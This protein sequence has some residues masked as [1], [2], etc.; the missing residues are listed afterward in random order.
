MRAT[1][2]PMIPSRPTGAALW[3][4][5]LD[6][7]SPVSLSRQLAAALRQAIAEGSLAAGARLPS[8][9]AL[10]AE[11]GLA[12]STVVGVF[13]QL[14]A[15]GYIIARPGSAHRVPERREYHKASSAANEGGGPPIGGE[16]VRA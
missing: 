14:T 6:R 10:A 1:L 9:R 15:E 16:Q 5:R 7:G 8:S 11:L 12:R 3:T 4:T 2:P 13:D